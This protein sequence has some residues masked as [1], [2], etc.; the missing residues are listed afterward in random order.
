[1][2][3]LEKPKNEQTAAV[4]L[5]VKWCNNCDNFEMRSRFKVMGLVRNLKKHNLGWIAP[6]NGKPVLIT[7]S[8][9]VHRGVMSMPSSNSG[10]RFIEIVSNVHAWV[11]MAKK[12][13]LAMIPKFENMQIDVG[14]T[15]EARENDELPECILGSV[16]VQYLNAMN[17]PRIPEGMQVDTLSPHI[18]SS[19]EGSSTANGG[20]GSTT[21]GSSY[22]SSPTKRMSSF[23]KK[24]S[25]PAGNNDIIN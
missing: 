16:G 17:V 20:V 7:N 25:S 15:I 1:M 3:E 12:G 14:M 11:Y 19:Y 22:L 4:K 5:F 9:S 10:V 23:F 24:K 6:Y 2:E 18:G 13:F 8:G 21:N